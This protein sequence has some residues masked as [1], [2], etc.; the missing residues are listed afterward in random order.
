MPRDLNVE[1][2]CGINPAESKAPIGFPELKTCA[3]ILLDRSIP[4]DAFSELFGKKLLG[5]LIHTLQFARSH[6]TIEFTER[7]QLGVREM[8]RS[9]LFAEAG[10]SGID[11]PELH[12]PIT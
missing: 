5:E 3:M 2:V 11:A 7:E 10:D 12:A 9:V 6:P 8:Q 4:T 1:F